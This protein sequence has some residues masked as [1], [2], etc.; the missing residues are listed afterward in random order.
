[1]LINIDEPQNSVKMKF[2]ECYGASG[3]YIL[4]DNKYSR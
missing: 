2:F 4:I 3:C 1:M